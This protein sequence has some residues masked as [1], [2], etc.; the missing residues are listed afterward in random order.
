MIHG[1]D[2]SHHNGVN[3]VKN[4][5]NTM[6]EAGKI[7]EFCFIKATEGKT[8][9]DKR[10]TTNMV[11]ANCYNLLRGAYHFA[12]P[13]LNSAKDEAINFLSQFK[14]YIGKAIPILDWE[15]EAE[16]FSGSWAYNWCSYV[17]EY[18]GTS[19][20]IY[21]GIYELRKMEKL[22]NMGCGLWIAR[23]RQFDKGPGDVWPWITWSCWQYTN[24]PF[25]MSV[26]NGAR[27]QLYK[28]T[29]SLTFE[30]EHKQE[31]NC[32]DCKCGCNIKKDVFDEI[33][34]DL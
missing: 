1:F 23:W 33:V 2:I 5:F 31:C 29:Q 28:Y 22:S 13:D 27:H 14:P 10:F 3:A 20:M 12:R 7:P 15:G 21:C 24:E 16:K 32:L 4:C 9:V 19:P 18:T 30:E 6:I 26:F 8:F 34:E 17:K 11:E 25:D